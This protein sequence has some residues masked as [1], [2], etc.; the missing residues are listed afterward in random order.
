MYTHRNP[1]RGKS[2]KK[3]LGS[4]FNTPKNLG[5]EKEEKP[6]LYHPSEIH[7]AYGKIIGTHGET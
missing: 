4:N 1:A 3:F 6:N 2:P 7:G 5:S